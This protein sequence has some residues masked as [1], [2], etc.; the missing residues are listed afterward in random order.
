MS[1]SHNSTNYIKDFVNWIQYKIVLNSQLRSINFK[2][3][4]IWWCSM[5][6]NLGSE[7]DGKNEKYNRPVLIIKKFNKNQ[8]WGVPLTT[9]PQENQEFYF[10]LR[11]KGKDSWVCLSQLRNFDAKR[12]SLNSKIEKISESEFKKVKQ[13]IIRLLE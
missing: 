1:I 5:G 4:E 10:E 8:F 7:Q 9:Q 13:R 3:R 6:I 11:V 12:L 2:E